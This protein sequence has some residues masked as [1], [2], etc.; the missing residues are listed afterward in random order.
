[1]R[2]KEQI[3]KN[4]SA[5]KCKDTKPEIALRKALWNVGLRF[6]VNYK[7][8]PGKPDIIFTRKR[9]VIFCDGAFWHGKDLDK[10]ASELNTNKEFWL[11]KIA[12][13]MKRDREV[14]IL[15]SKAGWTVLRFWDTEIKKDL[16]GC[17][18]KVL[19]YVRGV[20]GSGIESS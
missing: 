9:I 17:V 16:D 5:V 19:Q 1:M 6:R 7:G 2:T 13:N 14:N 12:G 11:A 20:S 4:M 10:T 8:L 15:L 18:K 3:S